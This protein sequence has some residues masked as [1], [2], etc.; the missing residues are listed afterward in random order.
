[1]RNLLLISHA[2]LTARTTMAMSKD[3]LLLEPQQVQKV[4]QVRNEPTPCTIGT[5]MSRCQRMV[6]KGTSGKL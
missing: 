5:K 1:M 2:A 6:D 3:L 4:E